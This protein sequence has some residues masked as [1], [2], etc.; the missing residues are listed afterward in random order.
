M[1]V[2]SL[3]IEVGRFL[4]GGGILR[5]SLPFFCWSLWRFEKHTQ[6]SLEALSIDVIDTS[7]SVPW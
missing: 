2:P 3:P 5:G 4:T 1:D 7:S 6:Y